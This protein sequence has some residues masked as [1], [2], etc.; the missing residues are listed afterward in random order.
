VGTLVA[1]PAVAGA[2]LSGC[3]AVAVGIS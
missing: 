1:T 2:M 3:T